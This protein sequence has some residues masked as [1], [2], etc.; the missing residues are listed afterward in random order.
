MK[1]TLENLPD[2]KV[3]LSIQLEPEEFQADLSLMFDKLARE[4]KLPGFRKGKAPRQL[5]ENRLGADYTRLRVIDEILPKYFSEAIRTNKIDVIAEPEIKLTS[6]L[7][8]ETMTFDVTVEV[9]PEVQVAG[10]NSLRVEVPSPEPTE[11]ELADEIDRFREHFGT[12]EEVARPAQDK[13]RVTID[14]S[15]TYN[16]E[17]FEP[18]EAKDYTYVVGSY[19]TGFQDFDQQLVGSQPGHIFE[20]NTAHPQEP[21]SLVRV[22]ALVKQVQQHNLPEFTDDFAQDASEFDTAEELRAE[23]SKQISQAKLQHSAATFHQRTEE[24]LNRLVEEAPPE[25]LVLMMTQQAA[26]NFLARLQSMG[27]ELEAYLE[28]T[29][30]SAE[31]F[32]AAM[33]AEGEKAAKLDLA[34]RAVA[35]AEGIEVPDD[36]VFEMYDEVMK[37][38]Q[39][40]A[41]ALEGDGAG[42]GAGAASRGAGSAGAS[43]GGAS[44]VEAT[45]PPIEELQPLRSELQKSS[46]LDWVLRHT[47]IVDEAGQ[48]ISYEQLFPEGEDEPGDEDALGDAPGDGDSAALGDADDGGPGDADAS[49]QANA[50]KSK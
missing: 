49:D 39:E 46:A 25:A 42:G 21:V 17:P 7:T 41:A 20:F 18:F 27:M 50:G 26:R 28:A 13:D 36:E 1:S 24:A 47:E 10:Y 38:R 48:Q 5:L 11:Q 12:L 43:G 16:G 45:R 33:R 19:T 14:L 23:F 22:K 8:D 30:Q 6:E 9:R 37:R 15:A 31:S 40:H 44:A 29:N 34:L 4:V 35:R 32:A 3:K 2:N